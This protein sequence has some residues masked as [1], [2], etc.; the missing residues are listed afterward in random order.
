MHT[1]DSHS[2]PGECKSGGLR[3]KSVTILTHISLQ[4]YNATRDYTNVTLPNYTLNVAISQTAILPQKY[5]LSKNV[6]FFQN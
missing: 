4:N 2:C 1:N 5:A 3:F 6:C